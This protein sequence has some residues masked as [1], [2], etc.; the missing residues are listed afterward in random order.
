MSSVFAELKLH[1]ECCKMSFLEGKEIFLKRVLFPFLNT[2]SV[3]LSYIIICFGKIF[4]H[5]CHS[6]VLNL[7]LK[8][9]GLCCICLEKLIYMLWCKTFYQHEGG[10][11]NRSKYNSE[12][13]MVIADYLA[14][15]HSPWVL[16][17]RKEGEGYLKYDLKN[18]VQLFKTVVHLH[19]Y[20]LWIFDRIIFLTVSELVSVD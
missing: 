13:L 15:R 19:C 11:N 7:N 20:S 9:I 16:R 5:H 10:P 17:T 12:V 1:Y 4:F 2:H 8:W 6:E 14:L 3:F 18:R